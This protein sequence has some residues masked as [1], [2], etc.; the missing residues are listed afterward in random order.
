[1][2]NLMENKNKAWLSSLIFIIFLLFVFFN[3]MLKPF[4]A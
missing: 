4:N 2:K 3:N 1:L